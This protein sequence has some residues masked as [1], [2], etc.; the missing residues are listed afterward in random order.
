MCLHR[1]VGDEAF[2]AA[3]AFCERDD[4]HAFEH[5]LSAFSRV[6]GEA[7]HRSEARRLPAAEVVVRMVRVA[8]IVHLA[9]MRVS[10]SVKW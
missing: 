9:Y 5:L 3:Q 2:D 10:C 7:D 6:R 1:G 8:D 4:A